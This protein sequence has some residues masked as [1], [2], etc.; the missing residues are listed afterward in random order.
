MKPNT[1]LHTDLL[2][3]I[4]ENRNKDYGAYALR[5]SYNKRLQISLLGMLGVCFLLGVLFFSKKTG[6]VYRPPSTPS[7]KVSEVLTP[8]P[9]EPPEQ[10]AVMPAIQTR[11][12]R[13]DEMPPRIVDSININKRIATP[14]E[15]LPSL[16]V[17]DTSSGGAISA[18]GGNGNGNAQP[19]G[20]GE[21][22]TEAKVNKNI[23][24]YVAE[25]MPQYPGGLNA[26]I[27]F[28]KKNL[29][30]PE[31][32]E[33][34]DVVSVKVRFVVNFDGKLE[35]FDVLQ[36]GGTTFDNEVIRV[37]KKMPLWIPGK[38]NGENVSVYYIVPVKF[39][40]EY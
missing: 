21:T 36:S 22:K 3:I 27:E 4:F 1:I 2:D 25:V 9:P 32:I 19:A 10:H 26:L 24:T 37:L 14:I 5:K 30:A 33:D 28:L 13:P 15:T 7:V 38:T 23:P 34:G 17:G 39:T 40:G 12:I 18:A 29:R 8:K 11:R 31:N 20:T 16:P 6:I 35:G